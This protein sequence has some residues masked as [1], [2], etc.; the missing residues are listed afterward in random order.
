VC[1]RPNLYY[2]KKPTLHD[3]AAIGIKS[4]LESPLVEVFQDVDLFKSK[5]QSS[6]ILKCLF[7]KGCKTL[8]D[9]STYSP[10]E[11]FTDRIT[12]RLEG[13]SKEI[14]YASPTHIFLK[15]LAKF[16]HIL[17][18]TYQT[19]SQLRTIGTTIN[20]QQLVYIVFSKW[21]NNGV[22]LDRSQT[23]H[24]RYL[25]LNHLYKS[26]AEEVIYL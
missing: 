6:A 7:N 20:G 8:N 10:V 2:Q 24:Q 9:G 5:A 26:Y 1:L 12:T 25:K 17:P 18:P 19:L 13:R 14:Y 15:F 11:E 3:K 22:C 16:R 21:I 4:I 23:F